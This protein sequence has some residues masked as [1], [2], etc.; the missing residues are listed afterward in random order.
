MTRPLSPIHRSLDPVI[1]DL[2]EYTGVGCNDVCVC[3][4]RLGRHANPHASEMSPSLIF[5][6]RCLDCG[7]CKGFRM[8]IAN[9]NPPSSP[10]PAPTRI[11][12]LAALDSRKLAGTVRSLGPGGASA[13]YEQAVRKALVD[14]MA[15]QLRM[16][17]GTYGAAA[18]LELEKRG[19][20]RSEVGQWAAEIIAALK[21]E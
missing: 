18:T 19:V 4:H 9:R 3:T 16:S 13:V 6:E 12:K 5:T 10:P 14:E 15:Y 17:S 8:P 11:S 7:D 21:E 1:A 20:K 2:F